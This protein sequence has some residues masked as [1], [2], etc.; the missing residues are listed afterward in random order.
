MQNDVEKTGATSIMIDKACQLIN[1]NITIQNE[2]N[3]DPGF[4]SDLADAKTAVDDKVQEVI[5]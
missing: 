5:K 2:L 3:G 4:K 1:G